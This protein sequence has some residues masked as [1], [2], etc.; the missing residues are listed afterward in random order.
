[1]I[2]KGRDYDESHALKYPQQ[3]RQT[4]KKYTYNTL[5]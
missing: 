4:I 2:K 5:C 1:M 3:L